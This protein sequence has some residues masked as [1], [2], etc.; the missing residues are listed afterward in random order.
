MPTVADYTVIQDTAVKLPKS[1]GD[2]D[3]DYPAFSAP[4]VN[5]GS[6]SILSFRVNPDGVSTLEVKLN[7]TSILTQTFDTDPQR[8]WHEVVEANLLRTSNNQ[9]TVTR[10]AG[11]GAITISDVWLGFQATIS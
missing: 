8:S 10:S 6:R 4:A 5:A 9:L 1:N 2:I 7:G 3:H 11:P